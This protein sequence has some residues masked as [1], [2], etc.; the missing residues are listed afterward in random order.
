MRV[1]NTPVWLGY[2]RLG[3][4]LLVDGY[5]RDMSNT[6]LIILIVVA[7][8]VIVAIVVVGYQMARRNRTAR[9]REQYGPEY[10]RALDQ[11]DS[12]REA[13]SELRDRSKRHE[14]LELRRLDS[15]EREDFE[16]RWSEVQGEFVD[17]PNSAVRNADRL[18]VEVMSARGYPVE[19]FDQRADDLSVS[20]P[21]ITQR[22]REA[23]RIAQANEDG[24]VDTEDLRQAVTSYRALVLA[25]LA[26]DGDRGRDDGDRGR[27]D[28]DRSR[29]NDIQSEHDN[30]Q[31]TERETKA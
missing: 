11:A 5:F 8:V 27:D 22:Y 21:E 16:R 19:D 20:H 29:Q 25:L 10:N 15:S 1:C 18:V 13:E 12:Q 6:T 14:K 23:S 4:A 3:F 24:T 30:N 7:V 2:H 28:G 17:D 26:D 31:M 9:L